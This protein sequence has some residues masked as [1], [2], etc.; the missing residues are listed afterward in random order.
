M[1]LMITESEG[2]LQ[3]IIDNA[4]DTIENK[5]LIISYQ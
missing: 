4:A 5:R 3:Y 1:I 2:L